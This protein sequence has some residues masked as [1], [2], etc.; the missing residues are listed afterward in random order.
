LRRAGKSGLLI[1]D[2]ARAVGDLDRME[3]TIERGEIAA[4][5][6]S[7]DSHSFVPISIGVDATL[8]KCVS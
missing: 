2:I 7:A 3:D 5:G 8:R 1:H 6:L 4:N